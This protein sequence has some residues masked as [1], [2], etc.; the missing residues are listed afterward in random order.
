MTPALFSYDL[1]CQFTRSQAD[2]SLRRDH[3]P[4]RSFAIQRRQLLS[5]PHPGVYRHELDAL[6]FTNVAQMQK[7]KT[8]QSKLKILVFGSHILTRFVHINKDR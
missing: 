3:L 5:L 6:F 8:E 4:F 1:E 2:S 7:Y